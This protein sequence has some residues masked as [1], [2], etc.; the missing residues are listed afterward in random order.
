MLVVVLGS[1]EGRPQ[2]IETLSLLQRMHPDLH[3][4]IVGTDCTAYGSPRSGS[5]RSDWSKNRSDLDF[6]GPLAW[7]FRPMII[8]V[9]CTLV[10]FTLPYRSLYFKL[11]PLGGYVF[12][13]SIVASDTPPVREVITHESEGLLVDFFDTQSHAESISLLLTDPSLRSRLS[14]SARSKAESYSSERGLSTGRPCSPANWWIADKAA[15]V[16]C[17]TQIAQVPLAGS[18]LSCTRRP[19]GGCGSGVPTGANG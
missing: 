12:G 4:L 15:H 5:A 14:V 16:G 1:I 3:V 18:A 2:F 13:C 8:T 19:L 10:L 17:S 6:T 7:I 9:F 11:E